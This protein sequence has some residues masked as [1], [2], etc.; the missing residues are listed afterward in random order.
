[1]KQ[2]IIMTVLR[3]ANFH[4]VDILSLMKNQ[5]LKTRSTI[6]TDSTL[7]FSKVP[8]CSCGFTKKEYTAY[9]LICLRKDR[10]SLFQL[11]NNTMTLFDN[12]HQE[13]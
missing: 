8:S 7:V 3:K 10:T 5:S 2:N 9:Y 12:T 4:S 1:M 13:C 11:N 6:K